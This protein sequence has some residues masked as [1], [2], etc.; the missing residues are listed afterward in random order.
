MIITM[1]IIMIDVDYIEIKSPRMIPGNAEWF[2]LPAE[3]TWRSS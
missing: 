2:S 1:T 3:E